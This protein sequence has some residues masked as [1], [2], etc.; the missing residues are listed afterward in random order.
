MV[1][2]W[3]TKNSQLFVTPFEKKNSRPSNKVQL[4]SKSD[5]KKFKSSRR[6][7]TS[8]LLFIYMERNRKKNHVNNEQINKKTIKVS[9]WRQLF[10][11]MVLCNYSLFF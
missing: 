10:T 11:D 5:T 3:P 7:V 8:S 4:L 2:S 1:Q 6:K 9:R